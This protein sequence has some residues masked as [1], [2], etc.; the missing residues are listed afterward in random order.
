M[1]SK[2][3]TYSFCDNFIARLAEDIICQHSGNGHDLRRLAVVFPGRRPALFLRQELARRFSTS[4]YPPRFFTIDEFVRYIVSRSENYHSGQDLDQSYLI[5]RLSREIDPAILKGRESFAQFLPWAK[6]IQRFI[7]NL[8]LEQVRDEELLAV[9]KSAA[10]GYS[11]PPEINQLLGVVVKLRGRYHQHMQESK[12]YSR[13]FLYRRASELAA[14]YA[15][16]EF[17]RICFC[18]FFYLN[19]AEREILNSLYQRGKADFYFQGDERHWPVLEQLGRKLGE[20]IREGVQ[21]KAPG[22]ELKLYSA[23]DSHSE[24]GMAVEI[25][26]NIDKKESTVVLLPSPDPMITLVSQLSSL[27]REFNV[28]MG[29]PLKRSSLSV[30]FDFIFQAQLSS[31]DGKY[32]A[33][34]YL[35]TLRHPLVKNIKAAPDAAVVRVL[36]HKLEEVLTGTMAAGISGQLFFSLSEVENCDAVYE[37]GAAVL[38]GMGVAAGPA[39]LKAALA[40]VHEIIFR[41]WEDV[42]DFDGFASRL[43]EF[44]EVFIQ[45]SPL[46]QY[47]LNLKIAAKMQDVAAE[48][49]SASFRQ[50][51]FPSEDI[52]KIFTAKIESEIIAFSGSP[53]KGLQVLGLFETRALNFDNVIVLDN[54]EGVLPHLRVQDPLIPREVMLGLKLDRLEQD[55]EILRYQFMRLISG[56][57]KVHLLY[58]QNRQKERSRFVEELIWLEQKRSGQ[59]SGSAVIRPGFTLEVT[60][61]RR[62]VKKT[63]AMLDFLR[64]GTFSA[65]SINTYLR[66]P[67][68]F[69]L[70]YVLGLR[71]K[72]DLLDE[73]E[74]RQVGVFVHELLEETFKGFAGKR[75]VI[76]GKFRQYFRQRLEDRFQR[77]FGR[78]MR[79]ESFLLKS[80]LDA[81]LERFLDNEE[82][83]PER[84]VEQLLFLEKDFRDVIPLSAGKINFVYKLDRVDRM[85]DGSVL[86]MDYKTGSSDPMPKAIPAIEAMALSRPTVFENVRSFQ[87]PLYFAFLDEHFPGE[88]VNAAFYNLRTLNIDYFFNERTIYDKARVKA[89]FLRALDFVVAEILNPEIDFVEEEL[90]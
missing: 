86:I 67:Y 23:F 84:R 33:P 9:E 68:E 27:Q 19:R 75:P 46:T 6:E 15:G 36:V 34:D 22:F 1:S 44:L 58:Q 69:Y 89:A 87:I 32:Y 3:I 12:I 14:Q 79:S 83:N 47:P 25:L 63:P 54:N 39:Q 35:K 31:R 26:K 16:D 5:Y 60:D 29:Y 88:R 78:S 45:Q 42:R 77:T 10:I 61:R 8:D 65:S 57:K 55:E 53:L 20:P 18:N 48:F 13:G 76:D 62:K 56:A 17:T 40:A 59:L 74:N 81:R 50:E 24:A 49:R 41:K 80:V 82:R 11:V 71:E 70:N 2:I 30:L 38:K 72:E 66:N 4:F 37:A 64:A 21:P 73:P 85:A 51:R 7:E 43:E 90:R 28:S 52:F